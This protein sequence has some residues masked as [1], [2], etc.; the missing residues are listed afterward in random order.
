MDSL[1]AFAFDA[2]SPPLLFERCHF[3]AFVFFI[4][5]ARTCSTLPVQ[6]KPLSV[7]EDSTTFPFK[8]EDE[9]NVFNTPISSTMAFRRC[10]CSRKMLKFAPEQAARQLT[11][12]SPFYCNFDSFCTN[13]TIPKP[14]R[15]CSTRLWLFTFQCFS[16]RKT[17]PSFWRLI[18]LTPSY[19]P[20]RKTE[21]L[22][23]ENLLVSKETKKFSI[24][25]L[26]ASKRQ[27]SKILG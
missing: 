27:K 17:N 20:Q 10:S 22:L 13:K 15:S 4:S 9:F 11:S 6:R 24:F 26:L 5:T 19:A 12:I 7:P 3:R 23:C 1:F 2:R 16:S 21:K 25:Y 14:I 8:Q 18:S